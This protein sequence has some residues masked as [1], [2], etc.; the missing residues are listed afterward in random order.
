[1]GFN[2]FIKKDSQKGQVLLIVLLVISV[3]LVVGLS[4]VSRSV[5]DIKISQQ[6]QE[7]ARALWVAMSGLEKAIRANSSGTVE[8]PTVDNITNEVRREDIGGQPELIYQGNYFQNGSM[9]LWLLSHDDSGNLVVP[10]PYT[11]PSKLKFFWG[12]SGSG[13]KPALEATLIYK[14]GASFLAKRFAYAPPDLAAATHFD[15]AAGSCSLAGTDFSYCSAVVDL[16]AGVVPYLVRIK[17]LL[18][19][20][21]PPVGVSSPDGSSFPIQGYCFV[22]TATVQE[23]GITRV[24]KECRYWPTTPQIFDYLL[25]SGGDIK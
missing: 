18:N 17:L 7:S 25:Y 24:P 23:S 21:S 13:E 22:S 2:L 16:P 19:D 20:S 8:F 6:S 10:N 12:E 5:T 14:S 4:V 1:M 9:T 11:G 3:I 15:E